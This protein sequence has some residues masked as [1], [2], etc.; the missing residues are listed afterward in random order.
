LRRAGCGGG[1]FERRGLRG[2]AFEIG[3]PAGQCQLCD[4]GEWFDDG[5]RAS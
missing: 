3:D 1:A 2:L 4:P 5:E